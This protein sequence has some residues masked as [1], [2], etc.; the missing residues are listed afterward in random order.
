MAVVT[1]LKVLTGGDLKEMS[2][3]EINYIKDRCRYLYGVN[4]SVNLT[5]VTGGASNHI[6]VEGTNQYMF[7]DRWKTGT[8]KTND[9]S[10]PAETTTGE[11]TIIT[12]IQYDYINQTYTSVTEPANTNNTRFPVYYDGS[13]NIRS[14]TQTD[15]LDT[16][17]EPAID[18]ITGSVGQPGT[19]RVHT[20]S[21]LAGYTAVNANAIFTDTRADQ[22]EYNVTDNPTSPTGAAATIG[23]QDTT[24]DFSEVVNNYYLLSANNIS[25]PSISLATDDLNYGGNGELALCYIDAA[26]NNIR[27]WSQAE[28][29]S[30]L[31]VYMRY[32]ASG[33]AGSRI[34][35]RLA[36]DDD[37]PGAGTESFTGTTLG[38]VI[39]NTRITSVA[40]DRKRRFVDANDYRSQ[41]FPVGTAT[42]QQYW[43]LKMDQY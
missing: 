24:Q 22:A 21:T 13:G 32:A 40:G 4:P 19:Y 25:N 14:M 36:Y 38:T 9:A 39:T 30:I 16:F 27:A 10:Y 41:E 35:F 3:A 23:T 8:A 29:D 33:H 20:S 43:I 12:P 26:D 15:M 5:V 17:I 6:T 42:A 37:G 7:D 28:F 1:P 34:R 31:S 18:T 11:P 2:T